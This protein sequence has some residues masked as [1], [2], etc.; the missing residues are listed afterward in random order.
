MAERGVALEGVGHDA[1]QRR[2]PPVRRLAE[3]DDGR[4]RPVRGA[5]VDCEAVVVLEPAEEGVL[6]LKRGK[7]A[8]HGAGIEEET[9]LAPVAG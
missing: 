2:E 7:R 1:L 8:G 4:E 6:L 9:R 5:V 3:G